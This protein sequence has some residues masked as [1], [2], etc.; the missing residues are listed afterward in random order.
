MVTLKVVKKRFKFINVDYLKR[1]MR[2]KVNLKTV[3][4][5]ILL[6]ILN[7]VLCIRTIKSMP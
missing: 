4:R 6:R 7:I 2:K 1:E 5:V 3:K